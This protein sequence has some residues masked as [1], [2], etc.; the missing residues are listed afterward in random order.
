MPAID[1]EASIVINFDFDLASNPYE[2]AGDQTLSVDNQAF[3]TDAGD[4][5][6]QAITGYADGVT[7]T[8]TIFA[9]AFDEQASGGFVVLGSAG[10]RL[11]D[12]FSSGGVGF[13]TPTDG[14]ARF[15]VNPDAVGAGGLLDPATIRHEV[16]HILGIGRV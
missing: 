6:E 10:P 11:L 9:S 7:R 16:G 13:T 1:A 8:V 4:F 3:F 12:N 5:W 15:N 14:A 2:P